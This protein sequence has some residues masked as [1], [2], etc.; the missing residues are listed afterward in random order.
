MQPNRILVTYHR[1]LI[2]RFQ[3]LTAKL[4]VSSAT[5]PLTSSFPNPIPQLTIDLT[6]VLSEPAIATRTSPRFF[7]SAR[8]QSIELAT[9][10][11]EC[12]VVL[13]TGE[14][15]LYRPDHGETP[16]NSQNILEDEELISLSHITPQP[17]RKFRPAFMLMPG[18]GSVC[19][20]ALSD[21]GFLASAYT[22]GSFYIVDMRGPSVISR[23][24][25]GTKEQN[26]SLFHGHE[27]N[28]VVSLTWTVTGTN[29][30]TSICFT[31]T[32]CT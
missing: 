25:S 3:D 18:R 20:F 4:L 13:K 28:P 12:G 9:E 5:M 16:S 26:K 19:A 11:L 23:D 21:I 31:V 24:I 1:D 27:A 14:I 17:G 10:S 29:T 30:G 32:L 22:D 8:I 15:A 6:P 7:D 2:I